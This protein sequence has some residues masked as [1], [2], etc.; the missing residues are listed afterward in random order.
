[1]PTRP[2]AFLDRDGTLIEDVGYL[3]RIDQVRFLPGAI[4]AVRLLNEAG[5]FVAVV[6]NQSGVARGFFTES[7]VVATH[8]AIQEALARE[9]ARVDAFYYCPHF[10]EGSVAGLARECD[11]RKPMAGMYHRAEREHGPFAR[12]SFMFGDRESDMG[13]AVAAGLE[14]CLIG[15]AQV[16]GIAGVAR[17]PSLIAAVRHVLGSTGP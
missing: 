6:T 13:F 8:D 12:P 5:F 11:C 2:A 1:M 3:A 15:D 14:P 16:P 17:F 10:R 4:E 7:L 9:D